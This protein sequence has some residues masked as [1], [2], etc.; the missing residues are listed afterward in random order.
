MTAKNCSSSIAAQQRSLKVSGSLTQTA[1]GWSTRLRRIV[2]VGLLAAPVL[3]LPIMGATDRTLFKGD[4][5]SGFD[6]GWAKELCCKHSAQ[7]VNSPSGVGHAVKFTL[8]RTDP[9]INNS[10]RSELKLDRVPR[11]SER[12]YR[13][14]SFLPDNYATDSSME[15]VAQWHETPDFELGETYRSPPLYLKTDNGRWVLSRRWD[16][17][18]LTRNN[19]PAGT[20]TIDLG[21]Y[22]KGVWTNWSFRVRWS[23]ESNGLVQVWKNGKQVF[24]KTGPNTYNDEIGTYFKMG[25]YKPDWKSRPQ[26]SQTTQ[27]VIYFDRVR[28]EWF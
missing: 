18:K 23:Y 27:R 26:E 12:I 22:Q 20:E 2:R 1:L 14:R 4:F 16:P 7:I 21:P 11:S 8:N 24:R 15:I 9:D 13:F 25:I 6:T 28:V 17:N 5:E 19:T 3:A 10:K